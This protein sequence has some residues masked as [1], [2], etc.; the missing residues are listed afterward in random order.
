MNFQLKEGDKVYTRCA[1]KNKIIAYMVEVGAKFVKNPHDANVFI[2]ENKSV[3][4]SVTYSGCGVV[5]NLNSEMLGIV[6]YKTIYKVNDIL[7]WFQRRRVAERE[8]NP[9]DSLLNSYLAIDYK[10]G[11]ERIA[12]KTASF[13]IIAMLLIKGA[14]VGHYF[15]KIDIAY[16]RDPNF[17]YYHLV[18][19]YGF[20]IDYR[21]LPF[22][23]APYL[24]KRDIINEIKLWCAIEKE[25]G[26]TDITFETHSSFLN[27]T[28]FKS[29]VSPEEIKPE[30]IYKGN[31]KSLRESH[32]NYCRINN[33]VSD[34]IN[35]YFITN[36]IY[37]TTLLNP[38]IESYLL[39][40][41]SMQKYIT[42]EVY[43]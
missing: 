41:P 16:Y 10:Q 42:N 13:D 7:F 43:Y 25:I 17:T 15:D 20:K 36:A 32:L 8:P 23:R 33:T 35:E 21:N 30:T 39:Q 18:N 19:E 12:S 27:D 6:S 1:I 9:E 29:T 4:R 14:N 38:A 24:S 31:V 22:G 34:F 40:C 2:F 3:I 37:R 26:E 5:L 11:I 28:I